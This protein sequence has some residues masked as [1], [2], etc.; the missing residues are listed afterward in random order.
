MIDVF[1]NP[2]T[3]NYDINI[4]G[5]EWR[6]ILCLPEIQNNNNMLSALEKWYLAPNYTSSC[7]LLGEQY[8]QDF[9]FFSVQNKMLGMYA[10]KYLGRF[11][12]IGDNGRETYWGIACKELKKENGADILQLRSELVNAIKALGLFS[13]YSD[14]E[15]NQYL[16]MCDLS[17]KKQFEFR[18]QKCA[19]LALSNKTIKSY[20]RNSNAS[21]NAL[22]HAENK[23]E[24]DSSH[25]SFP[26]K[27]DG[28]PYMETHHLIPL[29]YAEQFD[30]SIDVPENIICL[31]STC[32]NC[33][34]Y[35]QNN[36]VMIEVLWSMRKK[37]LHMVGIDIDLSELLRFYLI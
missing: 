9:R 36:N 15:V 34:H 16:Q 14:E 23:C 30:V 28:L 12:L 33:I 21:K 17:P 18:H 26:R 8:G 37:D 19:K 6:N 5:D 10:S 4:S 29:K 32:H 11:R 2:R 7:K 27:I 3:Q 22:L 13:Q 25:V 35:G 31:C 24:F 20:S 1:R